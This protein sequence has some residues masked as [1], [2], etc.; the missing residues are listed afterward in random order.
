MLR[1]K[2]HLFTKLRE[3]VK[4]IDISKECV[5]PRCGEHASQDRNCSSFTSSVVAQKSENLT[6]VHI[7]MKSVDSSFSIAV[8]FLKIAD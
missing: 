2:T 5:T 8:Y 6:L 3:V 4:H 7:D 1:A